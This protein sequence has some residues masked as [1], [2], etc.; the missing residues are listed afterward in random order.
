MESVPI[1]CIAGPV[2]STLMGTDAF[3]E[4]D[5]VG[6]TMPIT[7]HSILVK[8][9][10]DVPGA[11][12]AAFEI[13]GTGRPGPV[14]VD[15]TKDAQQATAPFVWPPKIDLPGYRPV[16]KA[17][18]K[19]IQAAAQ[20]LAG[21][22]KP[23]LYVGGGVIRSRAAAELLAFAEATG[24]PVVTTLMARGAFP[25]SHTQHLGMPGMHG[26]VPAVLAL[27]EADL[28]VSL[29]ARF[30][31]RVTGKA[32]LFAPHAKVV[33]VDIDP[34][35]ISKIRTADVPIVGDVR[36]VLTDLDAAFR[37]ATADTKPDIEEW[38]AYL[39]GLRH[40]AWVNLSLQ[41]WATTRSAADACSEAAQDAIATAGEEVVD[42]ADAADLETG[43][44]ATVLTVRMLP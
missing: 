34:A 38:W 27:Q 39:D 4:A 28:L 44:Y 16:T 1:V 30:D 29:G 17:H 20:L 23:V 24:A 31:D 25:D 7:K 13:A 33:H 15:I 26:T 22:Q 3:Q 8:R 36:D 11:I 41:F 43:N 19:Q 21:A 10:E 18:G 2:Y 14:L 32:S 35:E 12:A 9:P 40:G 6:I 5:I 42:V 37:G